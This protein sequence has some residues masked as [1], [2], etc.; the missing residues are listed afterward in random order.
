M[1]TLLLHSLSPEAPPLP[2]YS[3]SHVTSAGSKM[4]A[5]V[6]WR[7]PV[8][9]FSFCFKGWRQGERRGLVPPPPPPPSP[10]VVLPPPQSSV[11]PAACV[12]VWGLEDA[13][14]EIRTSSIPGAAMEELS[15]DEVSRHP[16]A[17]RGP[18]GD[19]P[20]SSFEPRV[21]KHSWMVGL[22]GSRAEPGL[23]P[24]GGEMTPLVWPPPT[25]PSLDWLLSL[26]SGQYR[27]VRGLC[28]PP[29]PQTQY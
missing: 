11:Y 21:Q 23:R 16:P 6:F 4:A 10:P 28:W 18:P 12:W 13:G 8:T 2:P 20:S 15:A 24:G 9:Y 19:L 29:P 5:V 7:V 17:T 27:C 1:S 26:V 25:P 14:L 22:G 3:R